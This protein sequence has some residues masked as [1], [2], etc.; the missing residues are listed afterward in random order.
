MCTVIIWEEAQ[1]RGVRLR[2]ERNQHK[3]SV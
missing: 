2:I 1:N 3:E